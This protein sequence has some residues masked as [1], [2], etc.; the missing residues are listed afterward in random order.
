[1]K[2]KA[3]EVKQAA[4]EA[5]RKATTEA[6]TKAAMEA[7]KRAAAEA[8]RRAEK[9][10]KESSKLVTSGVTQDTKSSLLNTETKESGMGF[11]FSLFI[12]F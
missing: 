6:K 11:L 3:E 7:E 10:A 2:L 9:D 8:E 5:E 1:A 4:L 12:T